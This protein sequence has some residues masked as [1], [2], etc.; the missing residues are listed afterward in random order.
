MGEISTASVNF[1]NYFGKLLNVDEHKVNVNINYSSK[2][3]I[4]VEIGPTTWLS[5]IAKSWREPRVSDRNYLLVTSFENPKN[6]KGKQMLKMQS[7]MFK[8]HM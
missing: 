3:G 6:N 5:R 4:V 8:Y 7:I 2:V 1:S